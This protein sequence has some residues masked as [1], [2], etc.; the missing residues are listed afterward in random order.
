MGSPY[1]RPCAAR[2]EYKAFEVVALV[3]SVSHKMKFVN[4]AETV[5]R[6]RLSCS[7]PPSAAGASHIHEEVERAMCACCLRPFIHCLSSAKIASD[8][9]GTIV[10]RY[11]KLLCI[12]ISVMYLSSASEAFFSLDVR[13]KV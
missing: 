6:K 4:W 11:N 10:V 13:S 9:R 2:R 7:A 3:G 12:V 8:A 1:E 5:L